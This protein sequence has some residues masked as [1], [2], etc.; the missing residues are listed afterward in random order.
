[1]AVIAFAAWLFLTGNLSM[2]VVSAVAVLVIA[3]PCAM[4]L[5][6]PTAVMVGTGRGAEMG[7]LFKSGQALESAYRAGVLVLDKT[8]TITNG[9]L[10]VSDVISINGVS[11]E[12]LMAYAGIAE[13]K[14]E[15]PAGRAVYERASSGRDIP[16]PEQFSAEPGKGVRAVYKGS[17]IIAG[18]RRFIEEIGID[19]SSGAASLDALEGLGKTAVVVAAGGRVAGIIALS[20]SIKESSRAAVAEL[21]AMGFRVYMVTGDNRRTAEFIAGQ[22]GIEAGRVIAGVLPGRK[23]EVIRELQRGGAMVAMVGDGINDA[24]A[25]AA[26]DIGIAVGTGTDIAMESADITLMSGDL[27]AIAVA[28]RLSRRTIRTIRQNFFWAFVYNCIGIPFAAAGMLSPLIAGAAMAMSSVSVVANSL[29]LRR[30]S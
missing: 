7:I 30:F 29:L 8:G 27:S 15:H 22:A 14:S 11:E 10:S 18:T 9:E 20:D 26:A 6:T 24:P 2:A 12:E 3:C 19:A 13:K 23:A 28:I 17:E 16:D 21:A 4:G 1:V 25:L 5:A